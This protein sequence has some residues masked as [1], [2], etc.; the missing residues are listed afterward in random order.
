MAAPTLKYVKRFGE[1]D[2]LQ[3][4]HTN[5]LSPFVEYADEGSS[6]SNSDGGGGT[7]GVRVRIGVGI[8]V[9]RVDGNTST[10]GV[11][12]ESGSAEEASGGVGW[13]ATETTRGEGVVGASSA[14][15]V[16]EE[17][18]WGTLG[19]DGSTQE[20]VLGT[21][22][23]LVGGVSGLVARVTGDGQHGVGNANAASGGSVVS[24]AVG[25]GLTD[26][27]ADAVGVGEE[28]SGTSEASE[29]RNGSGVDAVVQV[30]GDTVGDSV[31]CLQTEVKGARGTS[32]DGSE[33]QTV[34][35]SGSH[36]RGAD[37]KSVV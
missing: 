29:G 9:D 32:S 6:D 37:R 4:S 20:E 14:S 33:S 28:T 30:D 27:S 1:Q 2:E 3:K 17:V 10:G 15:A 16:D 19:A 35:G 5:Y 34:C 25:D 31:G 36:T 13:V 24:G 8:G 18:A 21:V 23:V 7:V 22:G 26:G 12:V 11:H